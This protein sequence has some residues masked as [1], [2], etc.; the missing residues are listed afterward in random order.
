[1]PGRFALEHDLAPSVSLLSPATTLSS[2]IGI[3]GLLVVAVM[4][5]RRWRPLSFLVFWF[6][7]NLALESSFLPLDMVFEHRAYLPSFGVV[8][9]VVYISYLLFRSFRWGRWVCISAVLVVAAMLSAGTRQVNATFAS[10]RT[11]WENVVRVSP[12]SGRAWF[13]LGWID[14][15]EGRAAEAERKLREAVRLSPTGVAERVMLGNILAERGK[16]EEALKLYLE[17]LRLAPKEPA[18]H[19]NI[20]VLYEESGNRNESVRYWESW[21]RL[22]RGRDPPPTGK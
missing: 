8:G 20:A 11:V 18:I 4:V 22:S 6:L 7:G 5:W 21:A 13:S 9:A 19:R 17:A 12:G 10:E 1:M 15:F 3:L 14:Y 2:F 16:R